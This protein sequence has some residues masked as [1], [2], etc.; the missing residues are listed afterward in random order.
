[1]PN[2]FPYDLFLSHSTKDKAVV[3][4]PACFIP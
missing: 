1:M 3:R 2:D 4:L